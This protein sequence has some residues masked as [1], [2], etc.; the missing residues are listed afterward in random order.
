VHAWE[1]GVQAVVVDEPQCCTLAHDL[2]RAEVR[3]RGDGHRPQRNLKH[4]RVDVFIFWPN[5]VLMCPVTWVTREAGGRELRQDLSS[6]HK[7]S[8]TQAFQVLNH[9]ITPLPSTRLSV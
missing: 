4:I 6:T 2:E 9:H 1:G 3:G 5:S 8:G 7:T